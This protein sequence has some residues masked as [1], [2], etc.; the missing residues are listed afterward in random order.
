MYPSKNIHTLDNKIRI[1]LY[2]VIEFSKWKR[3]QR[4]KEKLVYYLKRVITPLLLITQETTLTRVQ[5]MVSYR[6]IYLVGK[7]YTY[8]TPRPIGV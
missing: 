6:V 3:T 7:A 4:K 5:I 8:N 1:S 2:I